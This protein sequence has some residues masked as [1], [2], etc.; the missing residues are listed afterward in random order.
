[1]K[2]G[3]YLRGLRKRR[4]ISIRRLAAASGVSNSYISQIETG[5]RGIPSPFVIRQLADAL[6]V[7]YLDMMKA[8]GYLPE[9]EQTIAASRRDGYDTPLS[10]DVQQAVELIIEELRQRHRNGGKSN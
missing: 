8:A 6:D 5:Q 1:M 2:F 7:P 9:S 3:E 4:D 10:H